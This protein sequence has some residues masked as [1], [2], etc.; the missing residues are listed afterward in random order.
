MASKRCLRRKSC[1][2]KKR[3]ETM[4]IAIQ[5]SGQRMRQTQGKSGTLHAY[6]CQFCS[7]YHMGHPPGSASTKPKP[8]IWRT[9]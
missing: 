6:K 1:E 5:M 7:G 9:R 4:E 8:K 3:F 2:S